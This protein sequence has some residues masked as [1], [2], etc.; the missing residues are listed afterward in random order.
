MITGFDGGEILVSAHS[1][2]SLDRPLS[3]Y[4]NASERII[5]VIGI[6]V[7]DDAEYTDDCFEMII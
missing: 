7:P 3:S 5:H 4:T 1:D 6:T 2:D